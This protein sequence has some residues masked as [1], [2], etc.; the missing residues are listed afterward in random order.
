MRRHPLGILLVLLV[1]CAPR[2]FAEQQDIV[3]YTAKKIVTMDATNPTA[4]AVAVRGKTIVSV[5][6]LESLEPWLEAHPHRVD[7]RFDDKVLMP[8]LIDP[9]LHPLLGALQFGTVW[10]T[11][12]SWK[13][14]DE[15][16]P[17]T[18]SPGEYRQRLEQALAAEDDGAPLFITWGWSE[19]EHGPITR[20][21]LDEVAPDRPVMVWQR[22]VH[23]AVFNTAA[24]EYMKLTEAD[25]EGFSETEIDWTT[26][27]FVEAGLFEVAVPRLAPYLLAPE[28][29]DSGYS[30]NVDYLKANGVTTVGDLSTG[31]LDW[32]MEIAA[33]ERNLVDTG[34]P[35]RT[36]L[37][38]A[39]YA[40]SLTKG[41]LESSFEF[42]ET[43]LGRT[44]APPQIVYGKRIKLFA[45]GA[46]FSLLGQVAPP[47]YIDGHQ[48][49]WIT[50]QE[51]FEAQAAMYWKAGYRIHVHANGDAGIGFTLDVFEE[52]QEDAPRRPSALVI[53][54]FGLSNDDLN[55][56][57]AELNASVSANPY[58]VHAL[59]DTYATLGVGQD[60]AQRI[61]PVG[62]L[63]D[64][65]VTV[66]L[67]SDFGMAPANPIYLA[68]SAITRKT[69]SGE[70]FSP[71]RGLTREEAFRA[72]T[73]DAAYVL[74]LDQSL[75]SIQ[76]GKIAD[77]AV[78]EEDP[79]SVPVDALENLTAWGVVFEGEVYEAGERSEP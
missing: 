76:A 63:V 1:I 32:D 78:F 45:D 35:F 66:A 28:F 19:P 38:P 77:F 68:W 49:E 47:G 58:Y 17:A 21:D 59:G 46:M 51:Q 25:A 71:P 8:G 79:T 64:L 2:A 6:S 72:V 67:H 27:H 41:G 36:V 39:A 12:E 15:T 62:S 26:G 70:V 56:R 18:R 50:P 5:G 4:T 16:V 74:G 69:S 7:R 43:E 54:H 44:D 48:G 14:H 60:R 57:V 65:G 13:L 40:L 9:H 31:Q 53:E 75:G 20:A 55:R 37:V 23:E 73:I 3:V 42:V 33:L 30:R 29:V 61:A 24:L 11:P 52:L 22:S 10:I 34:A